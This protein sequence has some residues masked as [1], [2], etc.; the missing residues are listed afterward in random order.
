MFLFWEID[1]KLCK[2]YTKIY[3]YKILGLN[4]LYSANTQLISKR[5][6]PRRDMWQQDWTVIGGSS[7]HV[8]RT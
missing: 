6:Y 5:Q 1:I 7:G 2:I 3:I 4:R 8:I